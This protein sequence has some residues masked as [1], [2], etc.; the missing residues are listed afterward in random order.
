MSLNLLSQSVDQ[1]KRF[2]VCDPHGRILHPTRGVDHIEACEL[3]SREY[4]IP[5][6]LAELEGYEVFEISA[7][8]EAVLH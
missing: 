2:A 6:H 5:W 7:R 1:A 3:F 4:E 8:T